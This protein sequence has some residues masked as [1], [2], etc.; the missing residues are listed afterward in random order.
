MGNDH[1]LPIQFQNPLTRSGS[2]ACRGG[3]SKNSNAMLPKSSVSYAEALEIQRATNAALQVPNQIQPGDNV[4]N[5]SESY[6]YKNFNPEIDWCPTKT[7]KYGY[8]ENND[9]NDNKEMEDMTRSAEWER[10]SKIKN[11]ELMRELQ[12]DPERMQ[13]LKDLEDGK[14]VK[15]SRLIEENVKKV[16]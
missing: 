9:W 8:C 11:A 15:K 5:G 6:D 4:G 2:M 10:I 3:F 16:K 12:N 13:M 1:F 14:F 7:L